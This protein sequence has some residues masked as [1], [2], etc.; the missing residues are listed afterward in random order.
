[1]EELDQEESYA[2]LEDDTQILTKE[3]FNIGNLGKKKSI[4]RF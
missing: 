2:Y 1:M 3:F 4:N